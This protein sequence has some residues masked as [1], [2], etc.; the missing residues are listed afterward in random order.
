M[1]LHV[2]DWFLVI[3]AAIFLIAAQYMQRLDV[4]HLIHQKWELK[5]KDEHLQAYFNMN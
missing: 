4:C 5:Q 3:S 2:S 1:T